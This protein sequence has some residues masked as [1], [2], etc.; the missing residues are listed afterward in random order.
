VTVDVRF[1]RKQVAIIE[2]DPTARLFVDAGPGTGKTAVA[3]AR[4][5]WL[6]D[7][8]G[9]DPGEI[10][11]V[12][13]TRTAV[14]EMRERVSSQLADKSAAAGLRISTLDSMAW[15]IRSGFDNDATP[16]ASYDDGID[17]LVDLLETNEDAAEFLSTLRHLVVDEAQDVVG[18]RANLVLEVIHA[19]PE[20]AGVTVMAD[21]A[22]AIYGF[23]DEGSP[24]DFEG[25]DLP[26]VLREFMADDFTELE[27]TE[28]HRTDDPRL[29]EL[30][31]KGRAAIRDEA[32]DPIQQHESVRDLIARSRHFAAEAPIKE[33]GSEASAVEGAFVLFRRRGDALQ[34][35]NHLDSQ[36]RRMRLS[37]LPPAVH[38]W[39]AETLWDWTDPEIGQTEFLQRWEHRVTLDSIDGGEAWASLLRLAGVSRTSVSTRKLAR[40]VAGPLPPLE[41]SSPD[42]GTRGP[43]FG[44]I[45]AAKGREADVV[46][47]YLPPVQTYE[48]AD[49]Q[50]ILEETRVLYVGASRA[51]RE[52]H[53][54]EQSSGTYARTLEGGGRAYTTRWS[55]GS[56]AASVEIGHQ[57]D[58]EISGLVGRDFFGDAQQAAMAQGEVRNLAGLVAK[59]AIVRGP[60]PNYDYAL[61]VGSDDG[62]I[63]AYMSQRLNR[64][65]FTVGKQVKKM[66]AGMKGHPHSPIRHVSCLGA[67][68]IAIDPD[69]SLRQTLHS[70]WSESGFALAPMVCGYPVIYYR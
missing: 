27:L 28:I 10:W 69:D 52:L 32:D 51:R 58:V 14:Q 64:D 39:L 24:G 8:G 2:A 42:Y 7:T 38:P 57:G 33:L 43:I 25:T 1:R 3:V 45:H 41:L 65:L 15:Q 56:A 16:P 54:G 50:Q 31:L 44:T 37:G 70:P 11:L 23:A 55:R 18:R 36:P 63:A 53:V 46:W 68:T 9:L 62:A 21:E 48:Q 19:L 49:D 4:V 20:E 59:C 40:I 6:I 30:L 13:F 34:A 60:G 67:R 61:R 47:V 35:A 5:A 17:R 29:V 12:S 22:Q 26:S 66:R